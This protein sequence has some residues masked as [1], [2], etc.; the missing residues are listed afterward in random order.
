MLV[1]R[2]TE[3]Q[4]SR[5]FQAN[6][7]EVSVD[8][9]SVN[10]K[11][12]HARFPDTAT[13]PIERFSST[14]VRCSIMPCEIMPL[15]IG[16]QLG[17]HEITALLGKGGMGEVYRARDTKLKREV[18]IKILPEEFSRDADRVNR[19]HREA[20]VLASLNHPRIAAIHDLEE[21][22]GIHYLVLELVEGETLADR[23]ARGPIPADEALGI[24][25][26]IAE[27]L[28]AAHERG[29]IHRDL[30]P[31]NIKLTPD[32]QVKVLDFGLAKAMA[33]APVSATVSNSP[34]LLS[35]NMAGVIIG[36]AAYMSPE[37]ARGRDADQRSDIFAF[38]CVLYE[39]ITGQQAFQGED[40]SD[41]LASVMK[42]DPD[43]SRWP[44]DLNPRLLELLRRCLAKDRK[45]RWYASGDLRV[46][47]ETISAAPHD[48]IV[49][50]I[51]TATRLPLWKRAIPVAV[52]AGITAAAALG[53]VY[54]NR[55]PA[56][57]SAIL[58]VVGPP[59]KASF[60]VQ[61]AM[62]HAIS[63]DGRKLAFLANDAAGRRLVWVRPLDSLIAQP[64]AGTDDATNPF[65][66][67]D[68]RSIAFYTSQGR[69]KKV[70]ASGGPP[71]T[72]C[73]A[74]SPFGGTWSRDGVILFGS[75]T[76]GVIQRVSAAGGTPSPV[77]TLD[78]SRQETNHRLPYFLPDGK[79]FLYLAASSQAENTA[80]YVGS[81]ESKDQKRLFVASSL[82]E[83]APPGFL[84]FVRE[85][86]LMAQGFDAA[87]FQVTGDAF[88][89][90]E[91]VDALS[92]GAA[93]F[94]VSQ[95]GTLSYRNGTGRGISELAW[96][97]RNGARSEKVGEP[98]DY[99]G[100][101]LS[102]DG[103]RVV[104]H[105]HEATAAGGNLW[106][107]DWMRGTN[108]RFTFEATHEGQ[109]VWSPDGKR[110]VYASARPV[111]SDLYQKASSGA[112]EPLLKSP[113]S[114]LPTDWS[115]DG[116]FL[117]YSQGSPKDLF[118]LPMTGVD[119]KPMPFL[120]TKFDE[121]QGSFSPDVRWIA[122]ASNES[123][124]YQ[125]YV[126]PFPASG[127]EVQI[128]TT[129]GA[130]PSWNRNGRE[131]FYIAN[132]GKLMS[133]AVR[134]NGVN[135]EAE[136][137]KPMFDPGLP[138]TVTGG[139]TNFNPYA[140]SADGQRFLFTVRISDRALVPIT[141]LVNWPAVLNR[142]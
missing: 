23:I 105:A 80:I 70:D 82:A 102:P 127:A 4:S 76:S 75:N 101:Y 119:R 83:Y 39:M 57:A 52:T 25:K 60:F 61:Y 141:L 19:F 37:Q 129:G 49:K 29:I 68:S 14:D 91:D 104:V 59:D 17:S 106:I 128:S 95:N 93:S 114:K 122:Y 111:V 73:D 131:L 28:E 110:I 56:N 74:V 136:V 65:W 35:G 142:K 22:D 118:I 140:V 44:A 24:A 109:A 113:G 108:T 32:G 42:L 97:D 36:T 107:V 72:V 47:L 100:L 48:R 20:E 69:L 31:A 53:L 18:A 66:S 115:S 55:A 103:K 99:R 38:G 21:T 90:V 125:I 9:L 40:V 77:T 1:S 87:K 43:L 84:L 7:Q 13:F 54:W 58:F 41:V 98:G 81:I 89:I 11:L 86:T 67:P 135:F 130:F 51:P 132:D 112:E 62:T 50:T 133:V 137:P 63:P 2:T 16:S 123:G 5:Y 78:T 124:T 3:F 117:L 134:S 30:K 96:F 94:S 12:E 64:L 15:T 46:E 121:T 71:Q 10:R 120:Q 126:K 34:T 8:V 88:P 33:S 26:Q 27:A 116:K 138:L 45:N 6:V 92:N 85:H 79:H 139:N